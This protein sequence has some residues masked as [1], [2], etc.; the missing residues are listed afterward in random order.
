VDGGIW[1]DAGGVAVGQSVDRK[2]DLAP[3][4]EKSVY[5][6]LLF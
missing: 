2:A 3:D 6:E 5:Q 1:D 4:D